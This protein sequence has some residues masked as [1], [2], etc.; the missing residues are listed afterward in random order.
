MA[1]HERLRPA[2]PELVTIIVPRHQERGAAFSL[3]RRSLGESP[4]GAKIYMADT[5]GELGLFYRLCPFA[6][7]G[8]SLV[9]H[10]GQNVI[11]PAR[12]GRPVI[13]GPHMSNFSEPAALLKACGALVEVVDAAS[14]A[15]AASA[16]LK[17]PGAAA[18]AGARAVSCFGGLEELPGRLAALILE[19]AL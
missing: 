11:E 16:W 8:G 17:N 10:G 2:F 15:E 3:Q 13:T 14:L 5:L 19:T 12:L 6:F 18:E 4:A 7:V 9:A 1:A